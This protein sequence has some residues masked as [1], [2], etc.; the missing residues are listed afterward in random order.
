MLVKELIE[1]LSKYNQDLEVLEVLI[2]DGYD[3]NFYR[4]EYTVTLFKDDWHML[5]L[6]LVVSIL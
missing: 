3:C 2:T 5:T 6:V 1:E 4:G